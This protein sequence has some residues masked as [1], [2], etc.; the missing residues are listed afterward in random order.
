MPVRRVNS[1][2]SS[3]RTLE[4][5]PFRS[6][7]TFEISVKHS[8]RTE[9]ESLYSFETFSSEVERITWITNE[10][11]TAKNIPVAIVR[12]P[13]KLSG[14]FK[15]RQIVRSV[16]S[17]EN[18]FRFDFPEEFDVPR[19]EE[20]SLDP[21]RKLWS[22]LLAFKHVK[23]SSDM[24]FRTSEDIIIKQIPAVGNGKL[25]QS[26]FTFRNRAEPAMIMTAARSDSVAVLE[27]HTGR[28][29]LTA[30]S[31]GR[32]ANLDVAVARPSV[33]ESLSLN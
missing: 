1:G 27:I 28:E 16:I 14:M 12:L 33:S 23:N 8:H 31:S 29:S 11:V 17:E 10:N 19:L 32:A 6:S 4:S 21:A 9:T 18:L 2:R 20:F 22:V 24:F 25:A 3:P 5:A 26:P 7:I 13:E 30:H 15:R